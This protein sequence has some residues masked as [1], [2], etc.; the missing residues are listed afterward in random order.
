MSP[1]MALLG[2]D[3]KRPL[4]LNLVIPF[5]KPYKKVVVTMLIVSRPLNNFPVIL[6]QTHL[7]LL[8]KAYNRTTEYMRIC[9]CAQYMRM[10]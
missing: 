6:G 4:D 1:S 5:M 8:Q 10:S 2:L 9:I 7:M 3:V